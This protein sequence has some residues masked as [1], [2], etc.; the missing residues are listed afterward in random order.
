MTVSSL[1]GSSTPEGR[2]LEVGQLPEGVSGRLLRPGRPEITGRSR[3]GVL[4]SPS[5]FVASSGG[6]PL[7]II[8]EYVRSHHKQ[9]ALPPR[10]ERRGFRAHD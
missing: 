7:R 8:S 9:G 4:R 6:A 3:H 5:P 1:C 2:P 10:H